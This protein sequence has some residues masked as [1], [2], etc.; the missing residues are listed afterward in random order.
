MSPEEQ[1]I[2]IAEACGWIFVPSHDRPTEFSEVAVPECY[3]NDENGETAWGI[4]DLPDY[5]NDLNVMHEAEKNLKT[6]EQQQ[7]Y[8]YLLDL[9]RSDLNEICGYSW[10]ATATQRAEAFLRALN[11]WKEPQP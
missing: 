2:A 10:H 1:R 6:L 5:L 11:L 3:M 8:D 4:K 9:Q 7:E